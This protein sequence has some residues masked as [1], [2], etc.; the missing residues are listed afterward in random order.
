MEKINKR[1]LRNVLEREELSEREGWRD[2][3]REREAVECGY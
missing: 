2:G 1:G 3:E